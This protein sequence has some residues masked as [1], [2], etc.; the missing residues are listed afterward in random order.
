MR[1]QDHVVIVTGGAGIGLG[2]L[3]SHRFAAEGAAVIVADMNAESAEGIA[4]DIEREGGRSAAA[5]TNV[6]DEGQVHRMVATARDLFGRVDILVN[7]AFITSD[8]PLTEMPEE[9]WQRDLDV[10]LKGSFLCSREVLPGMVERGSGIILNIASVNAY[11]YFGNDAY[12]AAKA[13]LLNLTRS[14]AVRYGRDGIRANAVAPGTLRTPAWDE[15]LKKDPEI[16]DR[17][18]KWYP[19]G[20]VG[21][22]EDVV[23]PALFLCSNEARWISGSVLTVDGGLLAG[24]PQMMR[25]M[26]EPGSPNQEVPTL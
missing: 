20:R 24:N 16:F 3:L 11:S 15:R 9:V 2:Q 14:L 26:M 17:L 18:A 4:H 1:F 13:G 25:E 21:E 19:V 7:N 22:P 6:A 5:A 10:I 23:G 8:E 12:S